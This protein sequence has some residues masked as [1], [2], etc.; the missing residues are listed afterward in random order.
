MKSFFLICCAG[1]LTISCKT[2]KNNLPVSGGD[3]LATPADNVNTGKNAS[4]KNIAAAHYRLFD[5]F[6]TLKINAK[7]N[8]DDQEKQFAPNVEIQMEK[9]KQILLSS[10]ILFFNVKLYLTPER[11]SFYETFNGTYYDGDYAFLSKFL[12]AEVTFENVENLLLGKAFYDL[13]THNYTK[14]N[15]NQLQ[16]RLNPYLVN[17]MLGAKSELA[18]AEVSQENT[19]DK[20]VLSYPEYQ[21]AEKLFLPKEINIHAMQKKDIQINIDYRKVSVNPSLDF[22]YK[23]PNNSK[24]INF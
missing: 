13:N 18:S 1:L 21:M 8:Y 11:V 23:I 4:I 24:A 3:S 10:T 20:L 19:A 7:V 17:L 6:N 9:G 5:D 12:G 15:D 14:E 22:R 16:L 2:A